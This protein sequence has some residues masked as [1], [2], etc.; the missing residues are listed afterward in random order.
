MRALTGLLTEAFPAW[1]KFEP[2]CWVYQAIDQTQDDFGDLIRCLDLAGGRQDFI[3]R[4]RDEH[5]INRPHHAEHD[6][7]LLDAF[8]EGAAFA[9]AYDV[10]QI[11]LPHFVQSP[12]APDVAVG[13][14]WIEAKTV[15]YSQEEERFQDEV[16]QPALD[17]S[18]LIMRGPATLVAPPAG[19][20]EKFKNHFDNALLKWKRQDD[21]GNLIVFFNMSIDFGISRRIARHEVIAWA[22]RA[23]QQTRAGIVICDGY[24]WR[25]PLYQGSTT[26]RIQSGLKD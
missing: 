19:Y 5:P 13:D 7:R 14:V 1:E 22:G 24:N 16:I 26:H 15:R 25:N 4:L 11:G 23:E 2:T 6:K 20:L 10:A 9:W 12:G 8:T 18:G 17:R 21:L 3:T